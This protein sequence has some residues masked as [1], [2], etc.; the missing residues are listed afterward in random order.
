MTPEREQEIKD[1]AARAEK[2]RLAFQASLAMNVP[3]D[4]YER[5]VAAQAHAMRRAEL[6]DAEAALRAV[7]EK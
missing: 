6:Y 1:A 4:Y 3:Q 7:I 5:I 2:A